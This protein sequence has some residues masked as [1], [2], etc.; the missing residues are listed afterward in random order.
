MIEDE[1]IRLRTSSQNNLLSQESVHPIKVQEIP[2]G[3]LCI[4]H[5]KHLSTN[6]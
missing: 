6:S 4:K 2:S 1:E 5:S 3:G